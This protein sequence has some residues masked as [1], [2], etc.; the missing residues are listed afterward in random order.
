MP[1]C[2]NFSISANS[3]GFLNFDE[4]SGNFS[5]FPKV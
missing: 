4:N 5:G 1:M 2:S 3:I